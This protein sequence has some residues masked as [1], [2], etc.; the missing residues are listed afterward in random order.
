MSLPSS[1]NVRAAG[2]S[3]VRP[4]SPRQEAASLGSASDRFAWAA[5]MAREP[6][7]VVESMSVSAWIPQP[8]VSRAGANMNRSGDDYERRSD[9]SQRAF[10]GGLRARQSDAG[11]R[12]R[13]APAGGSSPRVAGP[14]PDRRWDPADRRV[15][16]TREL[17]ARITVATNLG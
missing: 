12:A 2:C 15:A 13:A 7:R 5:R 17:P 3:G 8:G 14:G 1:G 10:V 4:R 6:N 9:V 11:G 16:D